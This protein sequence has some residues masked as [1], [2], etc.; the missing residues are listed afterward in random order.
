CGPGP[1][2][3]ASSCSAPATSVPP[4]HANHDALYHHAVRRKVHG[5]HP[6]V[7]RLQPDATVALPVEALDRRG[8]S[9]HECDD[10][11]TVLCRV[12][13]V[14]DDVVAVPDV[15]V[16]HGVTAHRSEEHTSELQSR[17]NI[18]CRLLLE[19]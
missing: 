11:V 6:L 15:L 19:K 16:D 8:L 12:P 7:R 3:P 13:R 2:G 5:L 17:E 10:H 4:D 9:L 18:V 14:D 1:C